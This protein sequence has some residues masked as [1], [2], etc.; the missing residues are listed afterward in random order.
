V[1]G[2]MQTGS[3]RV[4]VLVLQLF[5]QFALLRG[6]LPRVCGSGRRV[7][8]DL[9]VHATS[10]PELRPVLLGR[11]SRIA[12]FETGGNRYTLFTDLA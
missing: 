12:R 3:L 4:V 7:D 1:P 9:L 2:L 8:V 11:I 10:P 6:R 5:L